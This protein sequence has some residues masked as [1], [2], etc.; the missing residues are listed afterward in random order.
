MNLG[1]AIA[2][3]LTVSLLELFPLKYRGFNLNDNLYVAP[4]VALFALYA[5]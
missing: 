3:S 5:I 1:H 4:L 2:L